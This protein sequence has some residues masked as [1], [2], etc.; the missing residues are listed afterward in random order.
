MEEK[1][2]GPSPILI[3]VLA[4]VLLWVDLFLPPLPV[5]ALSALW[6]ALQ[7]FKGAIRVGLLLLLGRRY[8]PQNFSPK[9]SFLPKAKDLVGGLEIGASLAALALLLA[10]LALAAGYRNPLLASF[11]SRASPKATT[12][13]LMILSCIGT[14]YSEELFFRFFAPQ[15]LQGAGFPPWA[16]HLAAS[17][18]FGVSHLGQGPFGALM[19]LLY[20]LVLVFF[21]LR[22]SSWHALSLGH[23]IYDLGILVAVFVA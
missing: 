18:L 5:E 4:Y 16:A 3:L 23:A 11:P 10:L 2:L 7:T 6:F 14:G 15:A 8:L 21:R 1:K 17:V 19:A 22:G 13:F 9:P 20:A 12:V